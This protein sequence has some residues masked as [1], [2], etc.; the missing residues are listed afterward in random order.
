[1]EFF[2]KKE[3]VIEI[4]LTP[5]GRYKLSKG[6]FKP[7]YYAFFD[8]DV[9]Y[10]SEMA[11]SGGGFSEGQNSADGRIRDETPALKTLNVYEGIQTTQGQYAAAVRAIFEDSASLPQD[12]LFMDPG[13]VYN[14][15]ELQKAPSRMDF[16][17]RPLGDSR[18][19]SDKNPAWSV[20]VRQGEIASTSLTYSSSVGIESIPQLNITV[21]YDT[22]IG[23][24]DG[25]AAILEELGP[26]AVGIDPFDYISPPPELSGT[27]ND[28]T[29]EVFE[30]GTYL[31]VRKR[32]LVLEIIENNS[33][34]EKKNMDLEIQL[35]S[36]EVVD[37]IKQLYFNEN[38]MQ[39]Y[40]E[41]DAEYFLTLNVDRD[42]DTDLI[43]KL[44]IKDVPILGSAQVENAVSTRDYFLQNIYDSPEDICE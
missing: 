31:A 40:T 13:A 4:K 29:T 33:K 6:N 18:L 32:D 21:E 10:N 7:V 26:G 9:L 1:M 12:P 43:K 22:Y 17:S 15:E 42:L 19:N 2:D 23:E 44:N 37:G 16:L 38:A 30:D 28:I 5:Y 14:R 36:S 27:L 8:D 24:I 39:V 11:V 34:Y 35:S 41:D 25:Y 20:T 3:E